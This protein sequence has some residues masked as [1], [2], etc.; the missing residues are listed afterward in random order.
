MTG[1]S[2]T[3]GVPTFGETE[4]WESW[5]EESSDGFRID[6][7]EDDVVD[8]FSVLPAAWSSTIGFD[9]TFLVCIS[10]Y[11]DPMTPD[12]AARAA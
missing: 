8:R 4:D 12:L 2:A 5:A 9:G 7:G 1:L 10:E 3:G 11:S 6:K